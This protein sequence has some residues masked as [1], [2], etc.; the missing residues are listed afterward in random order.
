MNIFNSILAAGMIAIAPTITM[1]AEAEWIADFDEAAAIAKA[2]G[3]DL[4]VDFTGSDWCYWCIK[5]HEEVFSFEEF[6][7][8]ASER[9]V[10]VALD[11]PN[12]AA[13]QA[14]VPN[15]ERNKELA[16]KYEVRGYP[17]ILLM[18]AEG[19]V[20]GR[21]GYQEGGP[22]KYNEHL[23][24]LTKA[25]K[26]DLAAAD[27]LTADWAAATD[28][29]RAAT[30]ARI[31]D[32]FEGLKAD[33]VAVAPMLD[34]VR[35][36]LELDPENKTGMKM[37]AV[38]ALL[39][40]G[41]SDETLLAAAKTLDPKNADGLYELVVQSQVRAVAGIT[42]LADAIAAIV[43]LDELGIKDQAI[44]MELYGSAAYWSWKHL[45]NSEDAL[46]FAHK[47]QAMEGLDEGNRMM[48]KDLLN[49]LA[50][51]EEVPEEEAK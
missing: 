37:R 29:N 33:S 12:D 45:D 1:A 28:A 20:Y 17:T 25:G 22:A 31:M 26:A 13:I 6:E 30:W 32:T 21:T 18:T 23:G 24:D 42:D 40:A 14:L 41:Q 47:L 34:I 15:P 7:T 46:T 35:A 39:G 10:L 36:G 50:P 2:E 9:F 4:L 51:T 16:S 27:K 44:A 48:L 5:L 43:K 38:K 19:V 8:Y 49:D 11:F 3:K